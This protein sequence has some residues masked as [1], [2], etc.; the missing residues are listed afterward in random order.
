[1]YIQNTD[2]NENDAILLFPRSL[3]TTIPNDT[4]KK[5]V[6]NNIWYKYYMAI[7]I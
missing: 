3:I 2:A 6:Q 1:M 7:R 5:K 4:D